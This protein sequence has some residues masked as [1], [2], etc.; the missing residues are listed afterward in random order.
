MKSKQG[1]APVCWWCKIRIPL[2][3][4]YRGDAPE[5]GLPR[6]V[7]V[8]VCTPGCPR[9]PEGRRVYTHREKEEA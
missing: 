7:G 9:R 6:G 5:M 2:E 1:S 3:A 4:P 8:I